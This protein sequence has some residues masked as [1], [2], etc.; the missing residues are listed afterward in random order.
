MAGIVGVFECFWGGFGVRGVALCGVLGL[1]VLWC[2]SGDFWFYVS[3]LVLRFLGCWVNY[4]F[5]W[6]C[7][8]V[9]L[10]VVCGVLAVWF[11][12]IVICWRCLG[13]GFAKRYCG[14]D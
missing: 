3:L 6:V 10:G 2:I 12:V 14:F 4:G 7:I 9:G 1:C 8:W 5:S 11:V 13:L